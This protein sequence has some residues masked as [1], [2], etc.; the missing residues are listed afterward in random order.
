ML[1]RTKGTLTF[2]ILMRNVHANKKTV[3][4]DHRQC[5]YYVCVAAW[6]E[7]HNCL[8]VLQDS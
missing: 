2:A 3:K 8:D 7:H 1:K 5:M 6:L 4:S